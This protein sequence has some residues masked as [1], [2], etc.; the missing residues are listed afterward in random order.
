MIAGILGGF[1]DD[2]GQANALPHLATFLS[3]CGASRHP[4]W[5][6][7]LA[8]FCQPE[9]LIMPPMAGECHGLA[10][11]RQCQSQIGAVLLPT[12][13]AKTQTPNTDLCL[14]LHTFPDM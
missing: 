2:N 4:E 3:V 13:C 5:A 8:N 6:E 10:A 1:W 11:E 14:L 9:F 7:A 12:D